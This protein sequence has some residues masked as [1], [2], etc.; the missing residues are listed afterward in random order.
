VFAIAEH[1][2][3]N[4]GN[5]SV[6]L[7][8]AS[9]SSQHIGVFHQRQMRRLMRANVE[10]ATPFCEVTPAF[11]ILGASLSQFVKTFTVNK[12]RVNDNKKLNQP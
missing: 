9:V 6:L 4:N 12:L 11:L 8:N 7:A 5:Q 2:R 10:N 3:L 1:F